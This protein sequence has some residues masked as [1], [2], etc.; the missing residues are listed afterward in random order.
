[1]K[2]KSLFFSVLVI[3]INPFIIGQQS[4]DFSHIYQYIEDPSVFSVNQ[5][6]GHMPLVPFRSVNDAL[7]CN[8]EL[9]DG[10]RS[11]NGKW[12]FHW[13]ENPEN[14]PDEFYKRHFKDARWDNIQVPGNWEMQGYG[15]PV[16]RN[17][18]QPFPA[19][20]PYIPHDYNPTGIYRRS[21]DIP[22]EW[23]ERKIF[24]RIEA[25][26]SASFLW[27][28]GKQVGYNQGANEPAEYDITDLV[29]PGGNEVTVL[30]TKYS[31]GTYLEDQ[32]F[33][34]LSGIFRDVS[35]LAVPKVHIRDYYV[36]TPLDENYRD[37]EL[38]INAELRNYS[39]VPA[40]NYHITARLFNKNGKQVTGD[41]ISEDLQV[42]ANGKIM[43][44]LGGPVKNPLKW[45]AEQPN[46]YHLT[47]EL[48]DAG[49]HSQEVLGNRI[50]FKT[51]EVKNQA[52]LVNGVPVKLNGVNSHMQHPLL[53]HAMDTATIRKD[54]ILMKRFNINCVR[55]SHY[56]PNME[57]L[58]MADEIGIYVVDET[59]DEA[60][61]TEYLSTLPA[62]R[63]AYVD[64]VTGMVLRDRNHP[65]VIFWSAGN[66]SGTGE[67]ICKVISAGKK[68]DPSRIFMYG[69]NTDDVGWKNEVPCEDIIGPRYPTPYELKTRIGEVSEKQDPR[70]SFM[71][72]YVAATGNGAGGL[73]EYWDLIYHFPR[74]TGGAVW[75][76]VSPGISEPVKLLKDQSPKHINTSLKGR[77]QL[78]DGKFGHAVALSGHDE[79][80]ETYRDPALDITG[81]QLTLSL[82]IFPREWNGYGPLITKGSYQFGMN[83]FTR[84]SLS[85]Y[86]AGKDKAVLKVKLP[87]NWESNWHHLAGTYDG[88]TMKIYV[89]GNMAGSKSFSQPIVNRPFPLNI[90]WISDIDGQEYPG[91]MSNAIFDR[92][93]VFS[94]IIP[95]KELLNPSAELINKS[96][97]WLEMDS[98]REEG[99]YYSMGIGGRTYGLIW[100]DRTPQPELWQ[101]KKSAQPV[102]VRLIDADNG[103]VEVEN[104][105]HFTDLNTLEAAWSIQTDGE[106][107]EQGTFDI[108][109][110]PSQKKILTLPYHKPDIEPGKDYRL[111][112]SFRLKEPTTWAGTVFETAWDQ[113]EMP[114]SVPALPAASDG[115]IVVTDKAGSMIITGNNFSYTFDKTTGNLS[116]LLYN[117]TELISRGPLMNVWRAPLANDMDLW[118]SWRAGLPDTRPDLGEF[119]AG[120]WYTYGF[121][122]LK[123]ELD[124]IQITGQNPH[125]VVVEVL[126]HAEGSSYRTAFDSKFTYSIDASGIITVRHTIT[127]QG[128]MPRW[129]PKVGC[130]WMLNGNLQQVRW[131]G[132]GPFETYPDRKTGAKFGTY[133]STVQDMY[134]PYLMP[135]DYGNRTDVSRV[136]MQTADGTGIE[137]SATDTPF[138]F[139]A[140]PYTTNNLSRARYPYQLQPQP[141]ITFD[142]D[143]AVSGVGGTAVSV[144]DRYRVTPVQYTFSY[145]VRPFK[146]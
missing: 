71:D 95:V 133:Q 67:N 9:S 98:V 116:S 115:K 12:K 47:L 34:R 52:I 141:D 5:E 120:S 135:Q 92:V 139:S 100:P 62:W 69:G 113:F 134:E 125:Q 117:G 78:V 38:K 107:T 110:Q 31:D 54:L 3:Y 103:Q 87:D 49:G 44:S 6:P 70:P 10:Y 105:Y 99:N 46:L 73:D 121:D 22:S 60:H 75:D 94:R 129:I 36:T 101:L 137:F 56:P 40:G 90:G 37:A 128:E 53:G 23:K 144:L 83:Q 124:E 118:T 74:L 16:F 26:T 122:Q 111:L 112:V 13:S 138:C 76:W 126:K 33:W 19:N 132:R 143:Y 17:V 14:L 97:L 7:T 140:K 48:T 64:R 72:E 51:V 29:K 82:W 28:N 127:P 131:Y 123:Y 79:W 104:R 39:S 96:C 42:P 20:P 81:N 30:V 61:A 24:L 21:F 11:L 77:G 146:D 89:D 66:E 59:G 15:D 63:D 114:W 109:L 1:M 88:K 85:F 102:K 119:P 55:T 130:E 35:L 18:S 41:F 43:V 58:Q 86:V 145:R 2:L 68:L 84:D 108:S 32:D 50:G 25:A 65:S 93:A 27:V 57:Y 136:I 91:K 4:P 45:S 8:R 106:M 142:L 80:I